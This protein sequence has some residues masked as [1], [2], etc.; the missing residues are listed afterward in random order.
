M[1][2]IM[3]VYHIN[4]KDIITSVNENWESFALDNDWGTFY[5]PE[6]V[7]GHLIWDFIQDNKT[8]YFYKILFEK[9]RSGK[10]LSPIPFRCDSPQ[11]KRFFELKLLLRNDN[12]IEITSTLIHFENRNTV[13]LLDRKISRSDGFVKICSMCKKI[14][15]SENEW[16]E[17]EIGIKR[18]KLFEQ[19]NLPAITHEICPSCYKIA[20]DEIINEND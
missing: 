14:A 9:V 10:T 5:K 12:S 3:L 8:R 13:N 7:I 6:K 4:D 15:L 17:I 1:N 16:T 2:N 20:V 19:D 18:L 11:Q